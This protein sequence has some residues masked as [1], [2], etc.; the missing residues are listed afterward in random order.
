MV[1]HSVK[2]LLRRA[3]AYEDI[4]RLV[5]KARHQQV[6]KLGGWLLYDYELGM[7]QELHY[8]E[9]I[10]KLIV[11]EKNVLSVQLICMQISY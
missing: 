7:C 2:P 3:A 10:I 9:R 8:I 11:S 1:P 4:E 5:W 6:T